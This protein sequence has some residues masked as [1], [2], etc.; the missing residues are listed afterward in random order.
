MYAALKH[1]HMLLALTS[2]VLFVLRGVWMLLDSPQ[3][4]KRW[5]KILPHVVDTLLLVFAVGLMVQISQY[6]FVDHWLTA[7][8][9]ALLGYIFAG[10]V[11]LK[12][13]KTKRVRGT[14]FAVGLLL[15]VYILGVAIKHNPLSFFA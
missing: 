13:G 6:P 11:A 14:A 8:V 10:V 3:L 1:P 15:Y 7:K 4:Q 2:G 12:L 5:V 9:F